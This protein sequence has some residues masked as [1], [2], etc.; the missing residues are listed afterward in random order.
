MPANTAD[1]KNSTRAA[2]E[3]ADTIEE[4]AADTVEAAETTWKAGLAAYDALADAYVATARFGLQAQERNLELTRR[5]MDQV[6]SADGG[7]RDL[8]ER[9]VTTGRKLQRAW[10]ESIET[11]MRTAWAGWYGEPSEK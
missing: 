5:A 6:F 9:W 7:A 10:L 4:I 8:T 11:G 3:V 1:K 2:S